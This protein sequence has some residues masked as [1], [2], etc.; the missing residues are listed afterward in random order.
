MT[1]QH[2]TLLEWNDSRGFG[3]IT[4][5]ASRNSSKI[6]VHISAFEPSGLQGRR[7]EVGMQLQYREQDHE[8]RPR[9]VAVML[10]HPAKDSHRAAKAQHRQHSANKH[11]LAFMIAA[12]IGVAIL[13]MAWPSWNGQINTHVWLVYVV[14]SVLTAGMYAYDKRQAQ[15]GGWRVKESTL[16]LLALLGG[17]PG[18]WWAQRKL[19]HKSQK[20]EFQIIFWIT[21]ACNLAGLA[22]LLSGKI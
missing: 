19:R 22:L 10:A 21:V 2:G 13:V 11:G 4:P 5:A 14:L 7:P 6:F 1:Y 17:W 9:A 18:A 8:G 20:K 3:F 16:H 12:L 15:Q